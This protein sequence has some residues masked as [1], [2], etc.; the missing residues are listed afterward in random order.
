MPESTHA[1]VTRSS[2]GSSA[3]ACEART[4]AWGAAISSAGGA[5]LAAT[6]VSNGAVAS[7]CTAADSTFGSERRRSITHGVASGLASRT[8]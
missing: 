4:I 5:V 6:A 8:R 7:V 1:I 3:S 2:P